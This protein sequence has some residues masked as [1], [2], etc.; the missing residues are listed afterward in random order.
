LLIEVSVYFTS[1]NP[2]PTAARR[3]GMIGIGNMGMAIARSVALAGVRL[4]V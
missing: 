2:M 1:G 4:H 3:L